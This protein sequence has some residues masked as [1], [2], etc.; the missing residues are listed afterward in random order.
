AVQGDADTPLDKIIRRTGWK[1]RLFS[2]WRPMT[3]QRLQ[4][5]VDNVRS[6]YQKRERLLARVT[7]E[8]LDFNEAS[9]SVTPTLRIDAGPLVKV[10]AS[11][12]KLSRGKLRSLLPIYQE[13]SVDRSLLVEG[14]RN[15]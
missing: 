15:L 9:N 12:A 10:S 7:L 8:K 6:Y 11:G 13:R 14:R 1:T 2:K 5:G 4:S 3:E